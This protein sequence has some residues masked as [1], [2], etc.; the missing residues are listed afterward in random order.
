M[1][2]GRI[3][4]AQPA[5]SLSVQ[6]RG[7]AMASGTVEW[8]DDASDYG[9]IVRDDDATELYVRGSSIQV[10]AGTRRTAG[11]SV[12]LEGRV[13]G[14]G[15]EAIAVAPV[16]RRGDLR[17][18]CGYGIVAAGVLPACPMCG[19]SAWEAGTE[20]PLAVGGGRR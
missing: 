4:I 11:D 1:T 14:M 16:Q 13:P 18:A 9:F 6:V 12:E 17:C 20:A 3:P 10:E 19:A 8:C 2:R 15:R 5:P 7:V